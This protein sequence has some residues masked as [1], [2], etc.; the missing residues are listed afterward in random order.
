MKLKIIIQN[1]YKSNQQRVVSAQG[2]QVISRHVDD[3][4]DVPA[5]IPQL[6][7]YSNR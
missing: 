5:R 4:G 2:K 6:Y 1:K 7:V 3:V